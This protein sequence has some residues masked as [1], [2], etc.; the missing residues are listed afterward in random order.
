MTIKRRLF[1]SNILMIL[2]PIILSVLIAGTTVHILN[3]IFG[4]NDAN[5]AEDSRVFYSSISY[6][7]DHLKTWAEH[8]NTEQIA[9]D[10][11]RFSRRIRGTSVALS[12]YR[13]S[14]LLYAVGDFREDPL[15]DTVLSQRESHYFAQ[16]TTELYADFSGEY[17]AV[18]MHTDSLYRDAGN[19]LESQQYIRNVFFF[20]FLLSVVIILITNLLLTRMVFKS[21]MVPLET[22]T[23]GV[24]QIRDGNLDYRIKYGG[25]DEFSPACSDFN[26][27]AG[28][29]LDMV[30]ARQKDDEN[31][32][33]LIAGIS[34]DLRTPLTSIKAYV[35]GLLT[36][37]AS[38]SDTRDRYLHTIQQ[39]TGEMEHLVS[40]LFLFSKLDIGAFPFRMEKINIGN[41]LAEYVSAVSGE[42]R[43][44]GLE[45]T[46][47]QNIQDTEINA[48]RIQLRNVFTNI[49][50]NSLKYGSQEK[51]AVTV[52]CRMEGPEVILTFTD[53]GPGVPE[54][55]LDKLFAIFYRGDKSRTNP[56]Q[57][58]GLGLAIS[59][60]IIERL[61]G[62]ARAENGPEG[63]LSV[64]VT[65]P[66]AAGDTTDEKYSDH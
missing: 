28:Q 65:F 13:G 46:I 61:G 49:M 11:D 8:G 16:D 7:R 51:G 9:A 64:I 60:K 18:L 32:R 25:S 54:D 2:I 55:A 37:V 21:I 35:E 42:Y 6:M 17:S 41:E 50:E 59:A 63:G 44:K 53:N 1:F 22:L 10:M 27:M 30:N 31:R 19:Y 34:H 15:I 23:Y 43:R 38:N 14:E 4:F 20:M 5:K 24:H 12:V 40:Q 45:I 52:S 66:A 26:E 48:D 29:L 39:K 58:S 56:G 3:G 57:G 36:G 62:L 47:T 33:E